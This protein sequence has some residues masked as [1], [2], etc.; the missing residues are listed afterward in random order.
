[1][2]QNKF[3]ITAM[4]VIVAAALIASAMSMPAFAASQF[5]NGSHH[6]GIS[7]TNGNGGHGQNGGVGGDGTNGNKDPNLGQNGGNNCLPVPC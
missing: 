3:I 1:M 2:N 7:G 5:K 6:N 4:V